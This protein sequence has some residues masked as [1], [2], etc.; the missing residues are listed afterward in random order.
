MPRSYLSSKLCRR[1]WHRPNAAFFAWVQGDL[2]VR[3]AGIVGI[4]GSPA[5]GPTKKDGRGWRIN[6]RI[7]LKAVDDSTHPEET[8]QWRFHPNKN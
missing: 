7:V 2:F 8:K 3:I 6:G 4:S 1:D 5:A